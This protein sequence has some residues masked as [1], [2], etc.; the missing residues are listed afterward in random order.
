MSSPISRS[1]VRR[2]SA[3]LAALALGL[4]AAGP[5]ASAA[6]GSVS[7]DTS[8][9]WLSKQLTHGVVHNDQ[10]DFDD[11]GLTADIGFALAAIQGD[12]RTLRKVSTALS[13]HVDSWTT[14]ADF[15]SSDVY[16]GP[17]AKALVFAQTVGLNA[18]DFGGTN[19][20]EQLRRLVSR[21]GATKGR[22]QDAS[23]SGDFANTIGQSFAALGLGNAGDKTARPVLTFLLDQ[24]C[25]K[26]YFRLD[27]SDKA[28]TDQ[29]C[30]GAA[31]A[32]DRAP[33][34]D[35]TALTVL[36]LLSLAH[37]SPKARAAVG[38]AVAWL[39]RAQK[40]DGS[41]G[42]G[43]ST[44]ASNA[45]STGLGGWALAS[46]DYCSNATRA[47]RW[48]AKL[49]VSGDVSGT[50]LAGEQGAIAYDKAALRTA[51]SSGITDATRDQF[52]RATAQAAPVLFYQAR[53]GCPD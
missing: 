22:I 50:P 2:L 24:Q 5:S 40:D 13:K 41:F 51:R 11:Y 27:F 47:A 17:T 3:V 31:S 33:D 6:G 25:S 30:D 53:I 28:E 48:V 37:P 19:L 12:S 43:P 44:E 16:A 10:Y 1:L 49:T 34:T 26:G 14:G 23:S 9:T 38:K 29:T 4:V 7:P 36:N 21:S 18:R 20:V 45:N 39:R 8:A 52:R 15:G 46:A 32:A 35:A 42:G